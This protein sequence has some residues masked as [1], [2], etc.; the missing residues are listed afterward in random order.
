MIKK[1]NEK[2]DRAII[3]KTFSCVGCD[4]HYQVS[5]NIKR[6]VHVEIL[7]RKQRIEICANC[8]NFNNDKRFTSMSSVDK[9]LKRL[10][11]SKK[12]EKDN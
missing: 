1:V 6:G 12:I 10:E 9:Y 3:D 8:I 4:S 5:E 11:E 2:K 7:E